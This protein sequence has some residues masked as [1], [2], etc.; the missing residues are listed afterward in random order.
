MIRC[1]EAC[2]LG[3]VRD[4]SLVRFPRPGMHSAFDCDNTQPWCYR[5][6]RSALHRPVGLRQSHM[7]D[8]PLTDSEKCA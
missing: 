7:V 1:A 5:L 8:T 6:H 3:V 2:F 4:S